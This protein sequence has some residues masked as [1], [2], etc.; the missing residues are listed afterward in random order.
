[1]TYEE[2]YAELVRRYRDARKCW[3]AD[4]RL[5]SE[6]D[7]RGYCDLFVTTLAPAIYGNLIWIP[8]GASRDV[9]DRAF[10]AAGEPAAPQERR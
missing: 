2:A 7:E 10:E 4:P 5:A 1:M 8:N 9:L 6:I 3:A